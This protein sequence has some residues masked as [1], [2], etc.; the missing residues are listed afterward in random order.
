MKTIKI[1]VVL[2]LF[3]LFSCVKPIHIGKIESVKLNSL[4]GSSLN[5]DV[6]MP[7][8]N[9]NFFKIKVLEANLNLTFNSTV[10]GGF[11]FPE[12]IILSAASDKSYSIP[13]EF[14]RIDMLTGI[15]GLASVFTEKQAKVKI[16]GTVK[17]RAFIFTKTYK[18]DEE[19][20]V[21]LFK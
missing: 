1:I 4:S 18:V 17:A 20:S 19:S 14:K 16:K 3:F 11:N 12:P 7:I 2:S 21:K 9:P 15:M 8:Q 6:K 5:I 13:I 10:L